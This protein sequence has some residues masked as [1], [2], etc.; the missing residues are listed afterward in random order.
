MSADRDPVE[1]L[2]ASIA[3]DSPAD[4]E[5]AERAAAGAADPSRRARLE[6]LR[7]VSRIAEFNR[8]H[9]RA[10]ERD[11]APERFGELLLLER[12]SAGAHAEVWRAWDPGLQREVALK[13]VGSG[14]GDAALLEEGRIAARMRHPHVVAIHGVDR[15]DGRVGLWMELVPGPTL[16]QEVR[17]RGPLDPATVKRLGVEI[18]SALAAVHAAG[19]L[20]RDVKPANVVRDPDGRS[21]LVDFGLGVRESQNLVARARPSGTPMYM[22]PELLAGGAAS[23][24]S[25]LYSLGLVLWFALA[26]RHPFAVDSIAEL[27]AAARVGPRPRLRDVRPGVPAPLAAIVE[28]AIAP[29]AEDRPANVRAFV[30]AL[31][32]WRPRAGAAEVRSVAAATWT[33]AAVAVAVVAALG[34]VA[35]FATRRAEKTAPSPAVTAPAPDA[36]GPSTA[37]PAAAPYAVEASFLRRGRDEAARLV[38]GDRVRPGDRLSLEV[39]TSRPAWVYVLNEDEAGERFLLFPQ[40]RLATKN[41]LAG[42]STFVLPGVL[43]GAGDGEQAWTV[44]SAGGRE[45]FLVV[46][47]PEPVPE[48]EA[49]LGRLPEAKPGRPIEY[50]RVGEATVERLRGVGGMAELPRE[51]AKPAPRSRAFDRFRALAGRETDVRGVWVRQ[52]VLENPRP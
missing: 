52:V 25:D 18:G 49:D 17:T 31:E 33:R 51:A 35:V 34:T 40:S 11:D 19:L 8:T 21:V 30:E 14:P 16:E 41:P 15:R 26:G 36:A 47:S 10:A 38:S 44:T 23:E 5:S 4:W 6:S 43:A 2:L 48:I 39:R 12:L 42:D 3:D 29:A 46:V 24:R 50:A 45:H 22:A 28:R 1:E 37:P 7:E 32:A 9:Q 20:H 27:T 13:L